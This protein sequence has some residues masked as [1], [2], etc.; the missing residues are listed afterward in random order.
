MVVLVAAGCYAPGVTP[1][2]PCDPAIDNC[3]GALSCLAGPT[4]YTCERSGGSDDDGGEAAVDAPG[5]VSGPPADASV[6]ARP[7]TD[8]PQITHVEYTSTVADCVNRVAPDPDG[9]IAANGTGQLVLDAIDSTTGNPWDGFVRFDLDNVIAGRVVMSVKLRMTATSDAKAPSPESG[10]VWK[11]Q[12][13][14]RTTLASVEPAKIGS[15]PLAGSQGAVIKLQQ[16]EWTLPTSSVA[17]AAPIYLGLVSA[18]D[19][20]VNYWNQTGA[21]PPKLIIDLQ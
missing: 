5:D 10:V 4:G 9:C 14:T 17:A 11:V 16:I 15:L 6:D 7:P 1:G 20:G 13:F 21:N 19:D 8:A 2:A 12:P 18:N 3:P